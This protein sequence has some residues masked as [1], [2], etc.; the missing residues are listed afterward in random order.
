M[1]AWSF[2]SVK[3]VPYDMTDYQMKVDMI[4]KDVVLFSAGSSK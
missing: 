2:I 4:S 3:M 1:L